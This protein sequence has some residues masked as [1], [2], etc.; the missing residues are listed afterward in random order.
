MAA[1]ARPHS[2][3]PQNFRLKVAHA[4]PR[5]PRRKAISLIIIAIVILFLIPLLYVKL[6]PFSQK[7]V[8]EDLAEA[9]GSTVTIQHYQPT[10]FP[11]GCVLDG[12]EFLHGQNHFK[13][14]EAEKLIIQGSYIG[15][16]RRHVPRIT[17]IAAHVFIPAFGSNISFDTEH[18]K[19]VVDE[20]IAN[21]SF[22]EFEDKNPRK[23]PF[24]FDVHQASFHNVEWGKPIAYRLKLHNP[25]PPGEIGASG[26]FGPWAQGGA[27]QTPFSG[28]YTFEHA[29]LGVYGGIAGTLSSKGQFHGAL[30]H[31]DVSGTTST[32]DFEVKS[33]GHKFSLETRFDAYVDAT[34][35]DT[36]LKRI[37][38][39]LGRTN[40]IV[41]GSVARFPGGKGKLTKLQF[42][43]RRGRIEDILGLFVTER[44]PMSGETSLK[45]DVEVP[46][47]DGSFLRKV[48]LNGQFGID[49]GSFTKAQTQKDVNELSAGARGQNKE[50]P[51]TV[52]TN[53]RGR[54]SLSD[55]T[56]HFTDLSFGIPGA[57]ANMHGTYSIIEPYRINLHGN[58]RVETRISKT[59]S[60]VKALL[61]KM[62][63]PFF[64][65]KKKGEI[66]P[67]HILGTYKKP[68]YGLDLTNNEPAKK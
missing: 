29:D 17:A 58:M 1:P 64:K 5:L 15:I 21:G 9:S 19:I 14:V 8:L 3:F 18:S 4:S 61:L 37:D 62:M 31:L 2:S 12:I 38:A 23:T 66:V 65:K 22:I 47:G 42:T 36:F 24:R 45:A 44:S 63:D 20:V 43:S 52:V 39:R 53:L 11:P 60:G 34:K 30:Q 68:L 32:P 10:Y 26:K 67:V 59:S 6:W 7:S 51:E 35:G 13:L 54:V 57:Q 48:K 33:G 50:N 55:G 41:Q 27:E 40:L 49:E 16:L 25:N 56:A 28:Q 46:P